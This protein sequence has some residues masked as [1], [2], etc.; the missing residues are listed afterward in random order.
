MKEEVQGMQI[1]MLHIGK[2]MAELVCFDNGTT[3]LFI[4]EDAKEDG[5]IQFLKENKIITPN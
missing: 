2:Y 3:K 1:A 4:S 5:S